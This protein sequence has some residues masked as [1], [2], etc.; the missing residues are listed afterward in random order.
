MSFDNYMALITELYEQKK[1]TGDNQSE[2]MLGYAKINFHR[3]KRLIKTAQLNDDLKQV[4]FSNQTKMIWLVLTEGWCGD[5]AQ[6]IPVFNAIS[7]AFPNIEL[8]LILRDENLEVMDQFLTNGGRSIPKL[9]ALN[10]ETLET[11]GTW[12]PRPA[13]AQKMVNDFKTI[14]NGDY[15][16]FVKD[17]QLWYAKDKTNE[18]QNEIKVLLKEWN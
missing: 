14:P 18:V 12:G 11:I 13:T 16:A 9:I 3:M 6:N 8:K 17:V 7:K 2:A 15:S 5:A 10:L 4:L 1:T